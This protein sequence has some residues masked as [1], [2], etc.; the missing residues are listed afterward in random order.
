MPN[1][2]EIAFL[3]IA[4]GG[5]DPDTRVSRG[6]ITQDEIE[7]FVTDIQSEEF[8][9]VID[10]AAIP[11]VCV[12]GRGMRVGPN[13]AGGTFTL[14]VADALTTQTYRSQGDKAPAHATRLFTELTKAGKK[15]GGHDDDHAQGNNCGCGAEDKLDNVEDANGPSI[16]GYI[17]R[18][19]GDIRTF[20]ESPLI[21]LT[22][23]DE[24]HE[25]IVARS[26]ELRKEKYAT[27]GA[28]LKKATLAVAGEDA[29]EQLTGVHNEVALRIQTKPG[30]TIDRPKLRE[31]YGDKLEVFELDLPNLRSGVEAVSL[32]KEEAGKKLIA[33]LYYNV[34]TASVL[35][36]PSLCV[37][38]I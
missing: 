27:A 16:L 1:T 29:I 14:V 23:S 10:A 5:I 20:L 8:D 30:A 32:T 13:A 12:D 2:K 3:T 6:E 15:I 28:D 7:Q 4:E 25:S 26:A 17:E 11:A 31:K 21:G 18:R 35:A 22:I 24:L 37:V 38:V 19:G 36:G 9:A 34:A 33:A